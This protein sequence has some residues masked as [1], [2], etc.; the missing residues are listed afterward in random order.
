MVNLVY[1]SARDSYR[2]ERED[3]AGKGYVDFIF[4]PEADKH[5]DGIIIEL[6][7]DSN[8]QAAINQIR[9]RQYVLKFQGKLGGKERYREESWVWGS[10]MIRKQR[11]THVKWKCFEKRSSN[12]SGTGL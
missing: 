1:L 10:H 5:N 11:P 2:I 7:I 6:K 4:Y 9:Q 12:C 3:K 8:A